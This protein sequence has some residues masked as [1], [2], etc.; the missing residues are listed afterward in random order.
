MNLPNEILQWLQQQSNTLAFIYYLI[1][2]FICF[3]LYA[4]DKWI[5]VRGHQQKTANQTRKTK[6]GA[7][8]IP[9]TLPN[10]PSRI[11]EQKLLVWTFLCGGLVALLAQ[12]VF[13]H[14]TKKPLF[15][16][17]AIVACILHAA[18]WFYIKV[19]S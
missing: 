14:K 3:T 5:A 11:S 12:Q 9:P 13:R 15:E 10:Y 1:T 19:A 7:T 17:S 18:A 8:S 4:R 16:I 2:S 6:R